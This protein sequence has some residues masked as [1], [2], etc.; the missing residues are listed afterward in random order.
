[1]SFVSSVNLNGRSFTH[2]TEGGVLILNKDFAAEIKAEVAKFEKKSEKMTEPLK[3]Q[4]FHELV[5]RLAH[6]YL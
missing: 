4:W 3:V 2:D 6:P 5:F 1:L